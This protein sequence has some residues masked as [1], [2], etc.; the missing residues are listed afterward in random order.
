MAWSPVSL[1][2]VSPGDFDDLAASARYFIT[3]SS[4]RVQLACGGGGGRRAGEM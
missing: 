2:S 4:V 1:L 3:I